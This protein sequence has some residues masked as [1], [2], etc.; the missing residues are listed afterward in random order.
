[1]RALAVFAALFC[2]GC[3]PPP[4]APAPEAKPDPTAESWYAPSVAELAAMHAKAEA[5]FRA[6]NRGEAANILTEGQALQNRLLAAPQPTVAAMIAASDLDDLYGRMLMADGRYGY[7]RLQFQKDF[8][9]WTN[10]IL[11][12][13]AR[14]QPSATKRHRRSFTTFRCRCNLILARI[15]FAIGLWLQC[16]VGLRLVHVRCPV[17]IARAGSSCGC[18]STEHWRIRI[19]LTVPGCFV[20]MTNTSARA[21]EAIPSVCAAAMKWL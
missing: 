5:A 13:A 19:S 7:A 17:V 2:A 9:R 14:G 6:G 16:L 21:C 10:W 11:S 18:G 20:A 3:A 12:G 4:P 15:L 8:T 1:M